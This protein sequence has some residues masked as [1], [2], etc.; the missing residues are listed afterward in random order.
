MKKPKYKV[1]QKVWVVPDNEQIVYTKIIKIDSNKNNIIYYIKYCDEVFDE[2]ELH[3]TKSNAQKE[4]K[5]LKLWAK[6]FKL[7]EKYE[8]FQEKIKAMKNEVFKLEKELELVKKLE[9]T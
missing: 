6:I 8:N 9:R 5:I 4:L 2:K 3:L 1:G 7:E